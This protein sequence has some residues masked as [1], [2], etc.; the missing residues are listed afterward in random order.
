MRRVLFCGHGR[1]GKDTACERFALATGL[2]NAGTVSRYLA[3]HVARRLGVSEEQAYAERRQNRELWR[4]VGDEL[5]REDPAF[6]VRTMF[7]HGDIGGGVRGLA[8]IEAVHREGMADLIVW[9]EN[10]RV[11]S[12]PTLEFDELH[13]DL[14]VL[15]ASTLD[16]FHHHLDRL[17]AFALPL[18]LSLADRI[19][20]CSELLAKR[21]MRV[22]VG[23][24]GEHIDPLSVG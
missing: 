15:N 1:A 10:P 5:R 19:A 23:Q 7:Q 20:A 9:V 4:A 11:P 22:S 2:R 14:L 21:P 18:V 16:D 3:P 13:C 17:A 12:D 24:P 6:L 8:E